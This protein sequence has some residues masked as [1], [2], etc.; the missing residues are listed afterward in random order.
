MIKGPFAMSEITL[1][2]ATTPDDIEAVRTLCW[3]Y[4]SFLLNNSPIDREITE[5]FYPRPKYEALMDALPQLHARPGGIMLLARDS[6]GTPVGCGMSQDL[7]KGLSEIK[8]VFVTDAARGKGVARQLCAA[9]ID[10]ARVDGFHKV[11]LD[12]SRQ[13]TAAQMLYTRLGFA[14]RGPYQPIPEDILPQLMFYELTL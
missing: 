12:T 5:T 2:T 3:A 10:Q 13:L 6:S 14:E 8:R 11:V 9:L 1:H 4:H 7:G